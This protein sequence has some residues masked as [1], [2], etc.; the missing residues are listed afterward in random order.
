MMAT[1]GKAKTNYPISCLFLT[2]QAGKAVVVTVLMA[3]VI[4]RR[5]R[6]PQATRQR[7]RDKVLAS[8]WRG[9]I[10]G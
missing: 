2:L 9:S 3:V 8:Q 4:A 10:N 6:A 1:T 5:V 7:L